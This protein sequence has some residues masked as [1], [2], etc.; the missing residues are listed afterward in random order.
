VLRYRNVAIFT[1]FVFVL[2]VQASFHML[3]TSQ[4]RPYENFDEIATFNSAHVVIGP[5]ADR[6]F[7]YGSIDTFLQWAAIVG[8][9][10]LAETGAKYGHLSYS[11]DVPQSWN[12]PFLAQQQKTWSGLDYNYFRGVDDRSPI[13][14]SRKTHLVFMYCIILLSVA[15]AMVTLGSSAIY[16]AVPLL[17]LTVAPVTYDQASQSLPNAMNAVLTFLIV[18]LAMLFADRPRIQ[19]IALSAACLAVGINFKV[20]ILVVG[21]AIGFALALSLLTRGVTFAVISGFQAASA[22]G[23]TF[24]ATNPFFLA[25]PDHFLAMT[26]VVILG[27]MS[28]A[29]HHGYIL[30]NV[31]FL[32]QTID[33]TLLWSGAGLGLAL[34]I[35]FVLSCL[36]GAAARRHPAFVVLAIGAA[37]ALLCWCAIVLGVYTVFDRYLL[38]GLGA[39]LAT[40]AMGLLLAD[41]EGFPATARV[42]VAVVAM[43][44][45]VHSVAHARQRGPQGSTPPTLG[46]SP[47]STP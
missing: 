32:A 19:Y 21:S 40:V 1:V 41:R 24:I 12:N 10:Y 44:F 25:N 18:F 2:L 29:P 20:D 23:V 3:A 14:I 39:F 5:A 36:L 16:V 34:A 7:R 11:N 17:L 28:S 37:T 47:P 8:Y 35:A 38:N 26:K 43:V 42:T 27:Q 4:G 46:I 9:D 6:T 13:F 45:V 31:R 33:D 15:Y 30:S 22:F